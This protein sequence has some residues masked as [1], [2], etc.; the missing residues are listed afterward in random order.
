MLLSLASSAASGEYICVCPAAEIHVYVQRGRVAWATDSRHPFAF[1]A[2]LQ[3]T[4]GIDTDTFRQ[5]VEE[6]RRD[7]LP[8]GETLVEWGLATREVV[9]NALVH[10]IELA[11][12]LLASLDVGQT[13]FLPRGYAAYSDELTFSIRDFLEP[14]DAAAPREST[15]QPQ[16]AVRQSFAAQLRASVDGL[17]WVDVLEADALIDCEPRVNSSRVPIELLRTTLLDGADFAAVRST[18]SSLVGLSVTRSRS[19]WCRLTSESTFGAAVSAIWSLVGAAERTPERPPR[20]PEVMSWSIGVKGE[21]PYR[22]A[23]GGFLERAHDVL[24]A[25]VLPSDPSSGP[26]AGCGCSMLEPDRA[27]EVVVRRARSLAHGALPITD[28]TERALDSI[29]FSLR[30]MVSGEPKLWCFGAELAPDQ[31]ETLWL[32]LDRRN[33][34]GLGWAYLGALTRTLSRTPAVSA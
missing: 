18:R 19:V 2:H 1:A 31:G 4:A 28:D 26:L 17:S 34:Q 12:E 16:R 30:T 6:C 13:L 14:A 3:Q 8:L 15:E 23:I 11:L 24:G 29:G 25:I 5:V 10:Q 33:S 21:T 20:R 32:F 7:R 27:L 9:R 22:T